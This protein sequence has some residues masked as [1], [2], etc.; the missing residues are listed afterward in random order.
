MKTKTLLF[1]TALMLTFTT[2]AQNV[3]TVDNTPSSVPLADYND[4]SSAIS[5]A[6]PGDIIYVHASETN[7]GD[8]IIDK[9]LTL[10]GFS[11]SDADK[12]TMVD[13][14][15]L[16]DSAS[17][18]RISGFY[19]TNDFSVNN[20]N[21]M[22]T[23]LIIENNYFNSFAEIFF[24]GDAFVSNMTIRGNIIDQL[25]GSAN[26]NGNK[27]LNSIISNNIIYSDLY[28]YYHESVVVENNIFLDSASVQ[29]HNET[30]GDLEVQD[31]VFYYNSNNNFNPNR[32]GVVFSN[33]LS[34][35]A[36][37]TVTA[38]VGTGNINDTDPLFVS[39]TDDN[40][41]PLIDDYHLQA[42][43]PALGT[44]TAGDD[45]GIYSTNTEFI[46]NN[47]GFT[48]GIPIVTIT[49]ITS[50]IIPGGTLNVSIESNSN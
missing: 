25:G 38:L 43:S 39:A 50:Q 37:N 42:G 12:R 23:N 40:F 34:Y 22:I 20:N 13:E 3:I 49:S 1:L 9:P 18:V 46:F 26:I 32:V 29:N 8:I 47:L 36:Q 27:Y 31:C 35:N 30:T 2:Q 44:G 10:I 16:L 24:N 19:F 41:D 14:V 21:T 5:N 17:D 7:Y 15:D 45:I 11:H 28:V 6:N 33:C 4:L 48:A